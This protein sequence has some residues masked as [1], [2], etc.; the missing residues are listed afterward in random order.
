M[1]APRGSL[2]KLL[3]C[4]NPSKQT[5]TYEVITLAYYAPRIVDYYNAF[6]SK[7]CSEKDHKSTEILFCSFDL[8]PRVRHSFWSIVIGGTFLWLFI[9]GCNQSQVQR[10]LS[11]KT[12]AQAK[13]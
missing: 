8:D 11:C 2:W 5:K 13:G 3:R 12:E 10:Y 1:P 9:Y 7:P 4:R 6:S